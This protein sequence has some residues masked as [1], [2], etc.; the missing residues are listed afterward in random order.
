[1]TGLQ[2]V[3]QRLDIGDAEFDEILA[4]LDAA[5]TEHGMEPGDIRDVKDVFESKRNIILKPKS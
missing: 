2:A 3:H 1:M 5:M 4:L